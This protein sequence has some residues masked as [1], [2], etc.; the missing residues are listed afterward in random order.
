MQQTDDINQ[1]RHD[2]TFVQKKHFLVSLENV[3]VSLN[4]DFP[5]Q[6]CSVSHIFGNILM[7]DEGGY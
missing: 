2:F 7:V 3:N 6:F 4:H 1:R 5:S